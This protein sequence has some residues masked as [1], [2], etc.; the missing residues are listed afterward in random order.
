[1]PSLG[2]RELL[3]RRMAGVLLTG[4][5]PRTAA[6]VV[7]SLGAVQS[8]DYLGAKW[9]LAQR[10]SG[11]RDTDVEHELTSGTILRTHVLRPTWHFIR[12]ADIRWMLALTAPRVRASMAFRDRWLEL[13]EKIFRRGNA[14]IAKA[15]SGGKTLTR[16]ELGKVLE[17]ARV[18]VASGQHLGHIV[19]R[20]ELDAIVCSG[21]RRGHQA[22]YALLDERVPAMP[23]MSRDEALLEL[24]R[25]YFETR[26][27]ATL[28]DFAWWSGLTVSD[29]K[30]GVEMADKEL[31]CATFDDNAHWFVERSL[32]RASASA[33]LLPNYDEY[34]IAYKDRTAV[35][36]RLGNIAALTGGDARI[37][38]VVF[39]NGELVGRWRRTTRNK[40]VV[41]E[42]MLEAKVTPAERGRIRAATDALRE[43]LATPVTFVDTAAV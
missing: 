30:R 25:R 8:Q 37:T 6:A 16:P 27:P 29:A 35:G 26:G 10:T 11:L 15:L 40:A 3:A 21:P 33:Q 24:A 19:M 12:P 32:E 9:A 34:F 20:A 23:S 18:K 14:A 7:E 17:R 43:F 5:R 38:H 4:S 13:D 39:V 2:L 31:A 36:Q 41:V 42:L 28:R 22:T 1:M